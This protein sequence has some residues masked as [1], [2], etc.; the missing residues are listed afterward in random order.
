[1]KDAPAQ[2]KIEEFQLKE[3]DKE[4]LYKFLREMEFNRLLSSVISAYGEPKLA[5]TKT[6]SSVKE[7]QQNISKK[8]YHL[9]TNEEEI[10]EWINEAEEAGE[11]VIDTETSSLD[12]HQADLVGISLSTKIGKA[13]YIPI[14]HKFEG[15][16][17]KNIVIKKLKPLL[18][19]KTH[20]KRKLYY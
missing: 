2:R 16:L 8:N 11:L 15:C 5:T 3:I 10:E 20:K 7:K 1:M 17:D 4:K 9:I 19:D 12:A 6:E 14:A 13:C 18:E